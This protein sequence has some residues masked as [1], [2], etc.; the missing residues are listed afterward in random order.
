MGQLRGLDLEHGDVQA[1]IAAEELGVVVAAVVEDGDAIGI[2][3]VA[4]GGEDVPIG[5]NQEPALVGLQAADS[6]GAVDLDH[7]RLRLVDD[8]PQGSL[9][10]CRGAAKQHPGQH[11][12]S[13]AVRRASQ[14]C[15]MPPSNLSRRLK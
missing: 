6:A 5:G 9:R 8:V 1:G 13:E 15:G 7:L 2:E 3:Y 14:A 4:Q 10:G 12:G 11:P